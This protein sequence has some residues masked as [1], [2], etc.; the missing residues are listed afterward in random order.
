MSLTRAEFDAL[1]FTR[2][3]FYTT[4]LLSGVTWN[5]T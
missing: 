2:Q 4:E 5:G 1:G 3:T